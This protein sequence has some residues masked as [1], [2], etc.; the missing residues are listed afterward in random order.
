MSVAMHTLRPAEGS[1]RAKKR[2]GRG[3]GSG[4][5]TYST[6]GAKGQRARS[7]GRSGLKKKGMKRI[8]AAMPKLG[9]FIS[10]VSHA[11]AVSVGAL[12]RVFVAGDIVTVRLLKK[13]GLIPAD[14]RGAKVIGTQKLTIALTLRGVTATPT[15]RAVIE[16]AGGSISEAKK[17][18]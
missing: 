7:G 14:A 6:R 16:Q 12:S 4:H 10:R 2:V 17:G 15:A 11:S 18:A 8:V 1:R 13:K 5:G 9:G 3:N